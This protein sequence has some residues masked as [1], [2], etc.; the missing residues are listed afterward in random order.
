MLATTNMEWVSLGSMEWIN[1]DC[2]AVQ[3]VNYR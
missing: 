1:L 3:S 2:E